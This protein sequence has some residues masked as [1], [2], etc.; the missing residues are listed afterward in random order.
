[1]GAPGAPAVLAIVDEGLGNSSYLI[2]VATGRALVVDPSRDPAPYLGAAEAR[3]LRIAWVAETHLHADFVS[4]ARELAQAGASV[5]AAREGELGFPHTGLAD[6]EEVEL[7]GLTLRALGTPGHTPE[8]LSF[9][10]LDGGSPT[11]V[12]TGGA[13]LPGGVARTDL[14]APDVT[15]ALAHAMYAEARERLLGLPDATP[16]YPTH[17]AGSF[18]SAPASGDR[19]TTIGRERQANPLFAAPDEATFVHE[20][21][22]GFGTYPTYFGRLREVNRSGPRLYGER[23]P[24]LPP[25]EPDR[26]RRLLADGAELVDARPAADFATGHVEGALGIE[27][28]PAFATWLGWLVPEGR[29]LVFALNPDQDR[30][31]LVRQCLKVG[32]EELAGELAGGPESWRAAGMPIGGIPREPIAG[33]AG[34]ILDVRQANEFASGHLPG[35]VNVELGELAS[36]GDLPAGPISVACAHG[37]RATTA[38]SILERRGRRDVTVLLGGPE[39]WSRSTGR[40]LDLS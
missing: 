1:V 22:E 23:A 4:G 33:A 20:L 5:L 40:R 7:G 11:G 9:A 39:D 32:Y 19:V 31:E 29:P 13:L 3:G 25:L 6:G 35:A 12:F 37:E 24:S 27:L 30:G 26:V 18:C 16:V 14:I 21:I 36:A 10:L 2:E 38:A 8:H 34:A 15:E 28:R 17:G